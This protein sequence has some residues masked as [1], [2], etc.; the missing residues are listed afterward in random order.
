MFFLYGNGSNSKSMLM[1]LIEQCFG[2]YYVTF[3]KNVLVDTS[4]KANGPTPSLQKLKGARIAV[5][6]ELRE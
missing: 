3:D 6:N 4:T 2:E 5:A 1:N